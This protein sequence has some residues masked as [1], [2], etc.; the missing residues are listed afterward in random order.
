[1][2]EDDQLRIK[3]RFA[4]KNK[5]YDSLYNNHLLVKLIIIK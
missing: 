2:L 4:I 3:M 1:M 5:E